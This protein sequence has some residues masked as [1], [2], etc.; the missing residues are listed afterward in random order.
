LKPWIGVDL[1][2][3]LAKYEKFIAPDHIGEPIPA[4]VERVKAWLKE[5]K[6]VKI[7]TARVA[8]PVAFNIARTAILEWC[9][10]HIG[11]ILEVTAT[12]DYGMVELW[13][14]RCI[15]VIPDTGQTSA[16]V[17]YRMGYQAGM[18]KGYDRGYRSAVETESRFPRGEGE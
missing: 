10:K 9:Y 17:S 12:K 7:F 11:Q 14:D 18:A 8:D 1:D 5:G 6:D 16:E 3:T 15:Q 13:D 4:M 2:G